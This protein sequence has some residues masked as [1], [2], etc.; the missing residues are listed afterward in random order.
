MDILQTIVE[1]FVEVL[2]SLKAIKEKSY[3]AMER[4]LK[5]SPHLYH[6]LEKL[7]WV[8]HEQVGKGIT[9]T[10]EAIAIVEDF[11]CFNR[12]VFGRHFEM[13]MGT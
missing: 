13:G 8:P 10:G 4:T 11:F 2:N 3:L 6:T 9:N 7:S 5:T 1:A 12:S